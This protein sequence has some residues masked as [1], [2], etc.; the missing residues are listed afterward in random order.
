MAQA[1]HERHFPAFPKKSQPQVMPWEKRR[2]TWKPLLAAL[3]ALQTH[4]Q[5][6]TSTVLALLLLG[7]GAGTFR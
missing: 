3:V 4:F 1:G 6:F 2:G 5:G 7:S